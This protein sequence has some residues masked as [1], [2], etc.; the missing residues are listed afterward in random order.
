MRIGYTKIGRSWNLDPNKWSDIGGDMD[1]WRALDRLARERSDDT[2]VLVGRNSGEVPTSVGLPPNVENPWTE[3]SKLWKSLK[4]KKDLRAVIQWFDDF[5]L[6]LFRELDGLIVWAGQHGTSNTFLPQVGEMWDGKLTNPQDSF[7]YYGAAIVRGINAFRAADPVSRE[8]IWLCP[9][10]RNYI[11]CR[12]LRWPLRHPVL[13]QYR[14]TRE[15]K[16]ERYYYDEPRHPQFKIKRI[17]DRHVWVADTQYIPSRLELTMLPDADTIPFD[18]ETPRRPFGM[19]VNENREYVANSRREIMMQWVLP[20]FRDAEFYGKWTDKSLDMMDLKIAPIP[21]PQMFPKLSSWRSTFTTPASGSKWATGKPW[22]A[23]L[24]GTICFFHPLYDA[25]NAILDGA[26]PNLKKWLRVSTPTDLKKRVGHL[27]AD[28]SAYKWLA[29]AQRE[30][31]LA[32]IKDARWLRLI[33]ERL[34]K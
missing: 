6:P 23:F 31:A 5:Q 2:F 18:L 11:K 13:A 26:D 10:P 21:I 28:D 17:D 19:I 29:N 24:A 16:F 20:F 32:A 12:D 34:S 27:M 7:V 15:Q 1:V 22:E 14:E 8:E 4:I 33:N 25:Q 9:D 30:H 3:Q